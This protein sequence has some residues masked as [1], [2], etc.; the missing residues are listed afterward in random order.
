MYKYC[1]IQVPLS[2]ID[3]ISDVMIPIIGYLDDLILVLLGDNSLLRRAPLAVL[4]EC[5]LQ[6]ENCYG[7]KINPQ[8]GIAAVVV[9]ICYC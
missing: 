3:L 4:A 6:A 7:N 5:R 1:T 9:A 8:A 2:P